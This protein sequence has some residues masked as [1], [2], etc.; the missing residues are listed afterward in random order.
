[1]CS[2]DNNR[3][4][5]ATGLIYSGIS[6]GV[7]RHSIGADFQ[8]NQVERALKQAKNEFFF[9]VPWCF[10]GILGYRKGRKANIYLERG[11]RWCR[12]S[13]LFGDSGPAGVLALVLLCCVP[14]FCPLYFFVVGTPFW[15][16]SSR[17]RSK[18]KIYL[19]DF[20]SP[21]ENRRQQTAK[22]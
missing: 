3:H 8:S 20:V 5:I 18:V 19:L 15:R 14:P 4:Y 2:P 7:L 22:Y 1:M 9:G 6:P 17:N 12:L 13:R 21:R 16:I 10:L 11:C